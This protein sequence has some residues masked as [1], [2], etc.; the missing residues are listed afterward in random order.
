L[1]SQVNEV[2][3]II[4]QSVYDYFHSKFGRETIADLE[5]LGVKMSAEAAP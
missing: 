4:A 2:G 1:L 3:P 5:S